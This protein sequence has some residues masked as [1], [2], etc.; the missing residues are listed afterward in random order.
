MLRESINVLKDLD[1][2][3]AHVLKPKESFGKASKIHT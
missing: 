3:I 1:V 2:T